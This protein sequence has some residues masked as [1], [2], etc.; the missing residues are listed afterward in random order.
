MTVLLILAALILFG[1]Y[2][3]TT[4]DFEVGSGFT[5]KRND[6]NIRDVEFTEEQVDE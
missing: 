4:M 1:I 5:E 6:K 3:V 2:Y